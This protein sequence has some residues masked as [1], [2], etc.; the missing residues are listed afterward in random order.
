MSLFDLGL[1]RALTQ[2]VAG[3]LGTGQKQGIAPLVWTSLLLI[4][5]LGMAGG[6]VLALLSPWLVRD[7]LR[8]TKRFLPSGSVIFQRTILL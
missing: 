5:G 7:V 1:G 6:A 4:F 2:L 3:R 8:V